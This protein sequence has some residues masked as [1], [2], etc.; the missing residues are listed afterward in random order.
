MGTQIWLRCFLCTAAGAVLSGGIRDVQN[1][2]LLWMVVACAAM[3]NG[4]T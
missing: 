3:G 4:R 2:M 1:K